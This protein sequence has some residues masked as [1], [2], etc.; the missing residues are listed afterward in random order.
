MVFISIDQEIGFQKN[1]PI[2]AHHILISMVMSY[3]EA[4]SFHLLRRI[5]THLCQQLTSLGRTFF[6]LVLATTVA[7]LLFRN[8]DANVVEN[9]GCFEDKDC[10]FIYT[11]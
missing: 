2:D 4:N 6:L 1:L 7:I 5:A 11:L 3:Q 10:I 8:M 9:R